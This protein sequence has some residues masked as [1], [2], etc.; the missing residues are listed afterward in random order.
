MCER[1]TIAKETP[2]RKSLLFSEAL[3]CCDLIE[4]QYVGGLSANKVCPMLHVDNRLAL[5]MAEYTNTVGS[6]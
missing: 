5:N 6:R 3:V 1:S 4:V 2:D